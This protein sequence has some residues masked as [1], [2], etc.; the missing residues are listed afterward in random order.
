MNSIHKNSNAFVSIRRAVV[1]MDFSGLFQVIWN[2]FLQVDILSLLLLELG[3]REGSGCSSFDV[4][5]LYLNLSS[6]KAM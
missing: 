1:E 4:L 5:V 3:W 2:S 6:I